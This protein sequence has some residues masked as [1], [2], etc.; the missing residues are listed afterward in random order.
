ML[1][2]V[3]DVLTSLAL[4]L[5][6]VLVGGYFSGSEL[7]LVTLRDSQ[8]E[9]LA[10]AGRRGA[11][12]AR[13]RADSN[14]LLASVQIGVTLAGFFASAYGGSTLTGPLAGV[15]ARWGLPAGLDQTV[16]LIVVTAGISYLSLVLGE[17][18]P[19]R[20][21]LQRPEG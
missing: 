21:A 11:K 13:L 12:V 1:E 2:S 6:F 16:A 10:H 7:A 9:R 4:V 18:A 5:V 19:K 17:L 20:L 3:S 14:R 15:L 8:V